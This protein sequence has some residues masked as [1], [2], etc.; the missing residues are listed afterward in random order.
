ML[1][2]WVELCA[3]RFWKGKQI[4]TKNICT[5]QSFSFSI[6]F[7]EYFYYFSVFRYWTWSRYKL[8]AII[9]LSFW[10]LYILNSCNMLC[11]PWQEMTWP[12]TRCGT[13]I[14][15][16][17]LLQPIFLI[18]WN[19]KAIWFAQSLFYFLN[20]SYCQIQLQHNSNFKLI[21]V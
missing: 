12:D 8:M 20:Y 19:Y 3:F 1:K 16:P 11:I 7:M 18:W 14:G 15:T 10:D 6:P 4:Q 5:V 9:L 13:L 21:L 17:E 2:L